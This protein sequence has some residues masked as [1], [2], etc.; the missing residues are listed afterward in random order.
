MSFPC[1]DS[2]LPFRVSPILS[3]ASLAT[4]H[5]KSYIALKESIKIL[6]LV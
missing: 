1:G 5:Y 3:Q 2:R 6:A 4:I